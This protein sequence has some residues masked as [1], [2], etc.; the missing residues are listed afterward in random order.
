MESSYDFRP[1]KADRHHDCFAPSGS[2]THRPAGVSVSM[3][4][5]TL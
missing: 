3:E 4:G 2:A 1:T 5:D